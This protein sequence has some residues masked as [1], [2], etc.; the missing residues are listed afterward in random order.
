MLSGS[1][2]ARHY[3]YSSARVK[4]MQSRLISRK[5]MQ[6]IANAKDIGT[7]ISILFQGDY[8]HDLEEFGGLEIKSELIDF[9]LSKNLAKNVAKLVQI[10]PTTERKPIRAI[11]GKWSLY[12]IKT[13]IEAKARKQGYE[14]I[15]RYIIDYGRYDAAAINEAMREDSVEGMINKFMI[16]SEYKDILREALETYRKTKSTAEAVAIIDRDYYKMLGD[17]IIGMRVIDNPSAR[18]IKMDID[19][20]NII[21]LIKAKRTGVKFAALSGSLIENGNISVQELEQIYNTSKDIE[22]M[23]LQAKGY[24]LKSAVEQYRQNKSKQLLVFE[25]GIRNSIFNSSMRLLSHSILSFG[26]ILAYAYMKEIEIFT[27]RILINSRLYGL[28]KDEASKL[29]VWRSE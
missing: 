15:S 11:A 20:K 17:V 9:A 29:I 5:T 8:K 12:N 1:A 21:Y 26:T 27:L 18:I 4:A 2:A 25:I 22:S 3:G 7:I 19:M 28:S 24:D 16:N 10:S 13:A 6:D 14:H 23:V